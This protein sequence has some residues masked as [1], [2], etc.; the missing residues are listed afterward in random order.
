[1]TIRGEIPTID[2]SDITGWLGHT[3]AL[4]SMP[5]G[6]YQFAEKCFQYWKVSEEIHVYDCIDSTTSSNVFTQE[7]VDRIIN[8]PEK[9]SALFRVFA[10]LLSK[11][12]NGMLIPITPNNTSSFLCA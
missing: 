12:Y 7:I 6:T 5:A 11:L 10:A 4:Y 3:W 9:I 1:M 8:I 2:S